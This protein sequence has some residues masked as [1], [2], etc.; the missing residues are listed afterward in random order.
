MY[1]YYKLQIYNTLHS[2]NC[3]KR[4]TEASMNFTRLLFEVYGDKSAGLDLAV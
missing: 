2:L 1:S 3:F 4:N